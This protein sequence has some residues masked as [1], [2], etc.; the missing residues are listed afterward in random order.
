[1]IALERRW[2]SALLAGFT[3]PSETGL[4]PLPNEVDYVG[5]LQRMLR[6]SR[7]AARFALRAAVW[8][9]ALAPLWLWGRLVSITTLPITRRAALLG[10]LLRHRNFVVRELALMLKLAA[11]MALMGT[12]TVRARSGYDAVQGVEVE[13]GVRTRLPVLQ[14]RDATA[15]DVVR[16]SVAPPAMEIPA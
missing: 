5:T 7:P 14:A 12:E 16:E 3:P 4:S 13:S 9:A 1:M 11:A 10:E 8:I 15:P 2:A 6:G